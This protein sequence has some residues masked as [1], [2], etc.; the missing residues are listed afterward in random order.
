MIVRRI[1]ARHMLA[2]S[3]CDGS[4]DARCTLNIARGNSGLTTALASSLRRRGCEE[5]RQHQSGNGEQTAHQT[6]GQDCRT[7]SHERSYRGRQVLKLRKL[8]AWPDKLCKITP[9]CCQNQR[10]TRAQ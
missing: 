4:K 5:Q 3:A 10:R 8:S 7:I 6:Q 2:V 1:G 9:M